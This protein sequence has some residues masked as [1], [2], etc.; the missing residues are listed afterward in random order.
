M[1]GVPG[2]LQHLQDVDD[3]VC[4]TVGEMALVAKRP[5][6]G[7][8]M[9]GGVHQGTFRPGSEGHVVLQLAHAILV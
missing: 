8:V 9:G 4:V 3:R 7:D 6:D 1:R 5:R 2:F